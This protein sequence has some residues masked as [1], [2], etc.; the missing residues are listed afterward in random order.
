M[1]IWKMLKAGMTVIVNGKELRKEDV[2][3]P[4]TQR[5]FQR[6]GHAM[7]TRPTKRYLTKAQRRT[8][9]RVTN[10]SRRRNRSAKMM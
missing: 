10:A 4:P 5:H 7:G 6:A 2:Q 3:K 1:N 8:K 9:R